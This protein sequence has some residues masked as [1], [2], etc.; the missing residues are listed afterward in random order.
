MSPFPPRSRSL[1]RGRRG[2]VGS[3]EP[4]RRR[5]VGVPRTRARAR[6]PCP[7]RGS[8]RPGTGLE[9]P[10]TQPVPATLSHGH[11]HA[12]GAAA[13]CRWP[14]CAGRTG[15]ELRPPSPPS[16]PPAGSRVRPAA[17]ELQEAR[18]RLL[19]APCCAPCARRAPPPPGCR[20]AEAGPSPPPAPPAPAR[21][22]RPGRAG[23]LPSPGGGA[24]L[25]GTESQV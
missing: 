24:R 18:P 17:P 23:S 21:E 25:S 6:Q 16:L 4:R 10:P 12:L 19:R 13:T 20:D 14:C 9:R 3:T 2:A 11:G 1:R 22:P 5:R 15:L 7:R 8:L